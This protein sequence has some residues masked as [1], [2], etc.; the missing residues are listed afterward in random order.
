MH[1]QIL[2]V[3]DKEGNVSMDSEKLQ[4]MWK[5][6][7]E[8]LYDKNNKVQKEDTHLETEEDVKGPLILFL[9]IWSSTKWVKNRKA[10]GKDRIPTGLQ[11]ASGANGKRELCDDC[12][13]NLC[14]WW[15]AAF[16]RR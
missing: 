16:S 6:Y 11:N 15:V 7:S 9:W 2:C 1:I 5:E 10:E 12:N 4:V 13:Q 3:R 8:Y 14:H